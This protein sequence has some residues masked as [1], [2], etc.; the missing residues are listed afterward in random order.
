MVEEFKLRV[1]Y[2]PANPP[3]P[4]PEEEEDE[5]DS[6]DSDVDHEVQMPSTFDGVSTDIV[7][8]IKITMMICL[9]LMIIYLCSGIKEGIYIWIA[10]FA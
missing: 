2:I 6:L 10:S 5:I 9:F 7:V 4:V 3:S 1:V 8:Y